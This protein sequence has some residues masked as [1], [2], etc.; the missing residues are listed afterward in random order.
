MSRKAKGR[1]A[2]LSRPG[3]GS[4]REAGKKPSPNALAN[5]LKPFAL[6]PRNIKS[7]LDLRAIRGIERA[8]RDDEAG[9]SGCW[10]TPEPWLERSERTP[11]R[12]IVFPSRSSDRVRRP[13]EVRRMRVRLGRLR[14]SCGETPWPFGLGCLSMHKHPGPTKGHDP[15]RLDPT[16]HSQNRYV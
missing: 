12:R 2:A 5:S 7:V 10:D 8:A 15:L 11:S 1:P 3:P 4:T 16:T 6:Q 13:R 9:R 14:R